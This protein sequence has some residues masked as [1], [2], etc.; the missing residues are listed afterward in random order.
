MSRDKTNGQFLE[1]GSG[2]KPGQFKPGN[3]GGPG[4]PK[5][6]HSLAAGIRER[7]HTQAVIGKKPQFWAADIFEVN[8][9]GSQGRKLHKKGDPITVRDFFVDRVFV[10]AYRGSARST[11]E[12]LD[13]VDGKVTQK[14]ALEGTEGGPPI[15]VAHV[16]SDLDAALAEIAAAAR[17]RKGS[18]KTPKKA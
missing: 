12:V 8:E 4:R 11:M 17:K 1:G 6:I 9:D 15:P 2:H 18:K 5:A 16:R 10:N 13:R 3:P 14:V 7:L